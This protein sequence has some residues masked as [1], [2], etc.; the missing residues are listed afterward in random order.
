MAVGVGV[1]VG[2]TSGV[3]VGIGLATGELLA[4]GEGL[5][6]GELLAVGDGLTVVSGVLEELPPQPAINRATPLPPISV[7]SSLRDSTRPALPSSFSIRDS[8]FS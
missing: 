6:S 4:V 1:G 5:A 2:L 3:G 7:I 8:F